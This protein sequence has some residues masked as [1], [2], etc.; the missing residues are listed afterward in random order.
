MAQGDARCIV[1]RNRRAPTAP[2]VRVLKNK[3][4][5]AKTDH[6]LTCGCLLAKGTLYHYTTA[7]LRHPDTKARAFVAEKSHAGPCPKSGVIN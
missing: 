6:Q 3:I 5:R 1:P 2:I 7:S 4:V